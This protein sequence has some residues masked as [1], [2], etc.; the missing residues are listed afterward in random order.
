MNTNFFGSDVNKLT[1]F[2]FNDEMLYIGNVFKNNYGLESI[3][4]TGKPPKFGWG[5]ADDNNYNTGLYNSDGCSIYIDSN[6][7]W[8]E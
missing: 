6:E 5:N 1:D 7:W 8:G 3:H 2:Y 4:F